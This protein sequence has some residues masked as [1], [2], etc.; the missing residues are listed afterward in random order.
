M[1]YL[2]LFVVV[3]LENAVTHSDNDVVGVNPTPN[4]VYQICKEYI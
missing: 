2:P 4:D 3:V 1:T